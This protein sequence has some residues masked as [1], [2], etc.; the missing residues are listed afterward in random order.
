[1]GIFGTAVYVS[2]EF[3]NQRIQ[4]I[5]SIGES[6]AVDLLSLETQFDL[7]SELPCETVQENTDLS[8]ELGE[9]SSRL[10]YAEDTLGSDNQEVALLKRQY[11]LLEIK[12]MLLIQRVAEK[13]DIEPVIVLYFYG[14]GAE[15]PECARQGS[16]LTTLQ[17][18]RSDIRVYSFDYNSDV[19]AVQTLIAINKVT[20]QLP[21]IVIGSQTITGRISLSELAAFLP[22]EPIMATS[23]SAT[24]TSELNN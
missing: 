9:L 16:I 8:R 2:T 24:T 21:A 6:V 4:E 5:R 19:P 23:T 11:F 15:C 17:Q 7:L 3:N 18:N 20:A 13:C 14:T 10:A 12:D 1:M 22:P